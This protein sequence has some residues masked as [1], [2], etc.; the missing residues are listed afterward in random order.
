LL[1]IRSNLLIFRWN[2]FSGAGALVNGLAS[3]IPLLSFGRLTLKRLQLS[4]HG[5]NMLGS[6]LLVLLGSMESFCKA[7][8]V[9]SLFHSEL[10]D[11]VVGGR[12]SS[13]DFRW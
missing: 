6:L 5:S 13:D 3:V 8:L 9:L 4:L 7:F 1:D 12:C 11:G 2:S 10:G